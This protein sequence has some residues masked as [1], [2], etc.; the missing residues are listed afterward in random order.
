MSNKLNIKHLCSFSYLL[1]S[2]LLTNA[3]YSGGEQLI[4]EPIVVSTDSLSLIGIADSANVGTVTKKTIAITR[5]L[6]RCRIIRGN[7]WIDR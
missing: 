1:S 4:L 2:M 6:S 3:A 5:G 7:T